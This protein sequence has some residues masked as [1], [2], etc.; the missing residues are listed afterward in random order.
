M[1]N[2]FKRNLQILNKDAVE[3]SW[4]KCLIDDVPK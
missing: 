3:T 2:N 4:L 1:F